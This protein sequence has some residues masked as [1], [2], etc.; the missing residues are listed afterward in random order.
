M[1][2]AAAWPA[3][4]GFARRL[5]GDGVQT[6]IVVSRAARSARQMTSRLGF[7]TV[8]LVLLLYPCLS[9]ALFTNIARRQS[10]LNNS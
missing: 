8:S 4:F 7:A 6:A 5:G 3:W 10:G 1:A 9:G 2:G